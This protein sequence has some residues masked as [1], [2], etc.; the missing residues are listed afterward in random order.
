MLRKIK[1]NLR[2]GLLFEELA[3]IFFFFPRTIIIEVIS[4]S[5]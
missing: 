3:L 1:C 4:I 2:D 5:Y